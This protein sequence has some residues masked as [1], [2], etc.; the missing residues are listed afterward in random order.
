MTALPDRPADSPSNQPARRLSAAEVEAVI[1]RAVELQAH[2]AERGTGAGSE[3]MSEAELIRISKELGLS[4]HHIQQ[5]IAETSVQAPVEDS[6]FGPDAVSESRLVTRPAPAVRE[7]LDTYLR[8]RE[9]MVVHRRFPDRVRYTRSSS[10]AASFQRLAGQMN[11]QHPLLGVPALEVGVR[12]VDEQSC[13]V[14]ITVSM[15]GQRTGL[16]TGGVVGGTGAGG[17]IAVAL[18]I[19]VAPPAA[20]LGLPVLL[21]SILG[22]R[23]IYRHNVAQMES[24]LE[25]LLDRLDHAELA[26]SRAREWRR[27]LGF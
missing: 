17:A 15:R 8:D 11:A 9:C 20:L 21:G 12:E 22:T 3:G 7:E 18:G 2:E 14:S 6:W 25:S 26:P 23:A 24:K 10:V 5:A 19:A 4:R 13:Y 27:R 1:R 16:A